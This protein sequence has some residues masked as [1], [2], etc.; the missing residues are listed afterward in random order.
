MTV[1]LEPEDNAA[2]QASS[3]SS[4]L[5]TSAAAIAARS[6]A[7]SAAPGVVLHPKMLLDELYDHIFEYIL[8][9]SLTGDLMERMKWDRMSLLADHRKDYNDKTKM[10]CANATELTSLHINMAGQ[11][12]SNTA[13]CAI[14]SFYASFVKGKTELHTPEQNAIYGIPC[15]KYM[16]EVRVGK[17][18]SPEW[19]GTKYYKHQAII[20]LSQLKFHF[21]SVT[22]ELTTV[23]LTAEL[24]AVLQTHTDVNINEV[25][26]RFEKVIDPIAQAYTMVPAFVDYIKASLKYEVIRRQSKAHTTSGRAWSKAYDALQSGA[27]AGKPTTLRAIA[28]AVKLAEAHLREA[29]AS[30]VKPSVQA[31]TITE[32]DNDEEAD[33]AGAG[34]VLTAKQRR[35]TE[36]KL[37]LAKDNKIREL[38]AQLAQGKENYH[39]QTQSNCD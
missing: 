4:A 26:Q 7:I 11:I 32:I 12:A 13:S 35:V 36:T 23:N 25:A 38:K 29:D 15:T 28:D 9:S 5:A 24:T 20:M 10:Q 6:A 31:A 39:P 16:K 21:E 22:A 30:P 34:G 8:E 18:Y 17:H 14:D 37:S 33:L 27:S 1:D 3:S 19:L 2:S